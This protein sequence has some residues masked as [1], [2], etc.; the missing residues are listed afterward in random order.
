MSCPLT[1]H[2][3]SPKRGVILCHKSLGS[4]NHT[5]DT[6]LPFLITVVSLHLYSIRKINGPVYSAQVD[7]LLWGTWLKCHS[8]SGTHFEKMGRGHSF[9][10][11]THH[12]KPEILVFLFITQ[13]H[14]LL[15]LFEPWIQL[16][17]FLLFCLTANRLKLLPHT[18]SNVITRCNHA[19][20]LSRSSALWSCNR[21]EDME[22][23]QRVSQ[24]AF[25]YNRKRKW[26]GD[27]P[28]LHLSN[29]GPH[30]NRSPG[31]SLWRLLVSLSPRTATEM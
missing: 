21:P 29:S 3:H 23:A 14:F 19:F 6:L 18:E 5:P 28:V 1:R 22:L 4:L 2:P 7:I 27:W 30:L 12:S 15:F 31:Q 9:T 16:R 26:S 11:V 10:L 20:S 17:R 24:T 13:R 8:V 25:P